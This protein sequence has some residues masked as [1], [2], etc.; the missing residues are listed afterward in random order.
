MVGSKRWGELSG[1]RESKQ[2]GDRLRYKACYILSP[3]SQVNTTLEGRQDRD[4][5]RPKEV[6]CFAQDS[7]VNNKMMG[8][9]RQSEQ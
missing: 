1:P 7:T 4:K 2:L 3:W 5:N 9:E 6:K 8:D